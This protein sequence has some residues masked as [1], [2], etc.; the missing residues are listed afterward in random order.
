M[1][2]PKGRGSCP[3]SGE[4][5]EEE[6]TP[7]KMSLSHPCSEERTKAAP[8]DHRVQAPRLPTGQ[9]GPRSPALL[10]DSCDG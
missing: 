2:I 1:E 9:R 6:P 8:T 10:V 7:A 3:E 4:G 5:E